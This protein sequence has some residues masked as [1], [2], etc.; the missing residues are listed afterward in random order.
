MPLKKETNQDTLFGGGEGLTC[1]EGIQS[2]YFKLIYRTNAFI[3]YLTPQKV[4]Q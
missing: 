1:L 3:R 2:A 4:K